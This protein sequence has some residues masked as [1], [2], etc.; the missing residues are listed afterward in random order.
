MSN[1]HFCRF[2]NFILEEG[3]TPFYKVLDKRDGKTFV[4][5]VFCKENMDELAKEKMSREE[6][7][8]LVNERQKEALLERNKMIMEAEMQGKRVEIIEDR[9]KWKEEREKFINENY[10]KWS[11]QYLVENGFKWIKE[12]VDYPLNCRICQTD[13]KKTS[14][15]LARK[16][17]MEEMN[18]KFGAGKFELISNYCIPCLEKVVYSALARMAREKLFFVENYEEFKEIIDEGKDKAEKN[19]SR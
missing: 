7:N 17:G 5:C 12:I 13:I 10:K 4:S 8:N 2:C 11:R 9:E 1:Y 15:Y 14:H 3:K 16:Q 19:N 18:K 6:F